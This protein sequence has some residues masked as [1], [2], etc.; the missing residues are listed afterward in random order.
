M[1]SGRF[2]VPSPV[3]AVFLPSP[4]RSILPPKLVRWQAE[5]RAF[6]VSGERWADWIQRIQELLRREPVGF[7]RSAQPVLHVPCLHMKK[8]RR[9]F[10]PGRNFGVSVSL[11]DGFDD[12]VNDLDPPA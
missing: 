9:G 3:G 7:A 1:H 11:V 10:P 8:A 2:E 6:V 4:H 5:S 12:Y